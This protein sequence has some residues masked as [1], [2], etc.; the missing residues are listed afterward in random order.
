MKEKH[1]QMG[2]NERVGAIGLADMAVFPSAAPTQEVKR[3]FNSMRKKTTVNKQQRLIEA[4]AN[5]IRLAMAGNPWGTLFEPGSN[6]ELAYLMGAAHGLK[7]AKNE[8]VYAPAEF[9]IIEDKR[10]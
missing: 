3:R 2:S 1:E 10:K 9:K 6:I 8:N 5:S 4:R 7:W